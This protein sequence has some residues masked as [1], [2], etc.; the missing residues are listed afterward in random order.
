MGVIIMEL[1]LSGVI[2]V[3]LILFTIIMCHWEKRRK[4]KIFLYACSSILLTM[5]SIIYVINK[6][7][8]KK[9]LLTLLILFIICEFIIAIIFKKNNYMFLAKYLILFANGIILVAIGFSEFKYLIG[10]G[11]L[12][13]LI[14]AFFFNI[15]LLNMD[16]NE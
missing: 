10:G 3:T 1:S 13:L 15:K 2:I 6:T 4:N 12:T 9:D 5:L 14:F 16:V 8:F 11:N 7:H